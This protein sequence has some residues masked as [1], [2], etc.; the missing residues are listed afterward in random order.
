MI[1]KMKF[2]VGFLCFMAWMM[3]A[4]TGFAAP[5]YPKLT[6]RVVDKASLLTATEKKQL[7]NQLKAHEEKSSDQLVIVTLPSL[8][9]YD[10]AD[11]SLNLARHWKIGQKDKDNGVLLVIAPKENKVRI[12]VGYG[13][14]GTLTDALSKLIIVR[15][16]AP[17]YKRGKAYQA[18]QSG[19]NEII[20]VLSG[21]A[22]EVRAR[23]KP[24]PEPVPWFV[25]LFLL[26]SLGIV[27][28]VLIKW[29][30]PVSEEEK[31]RRKKRAQHR[32][33][34]RKDRD[35]DD[36]SSSSS[37][38]SSSGSRWFGGGG[39]FGGGGSSSNLGSSD[40]GGGG[41]DD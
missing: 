29:L 8:Q 34:S 7:T 31:R 39:D 32:K 33:K 6:G 1:V 27:I 40:D 25:W 13:L 28:F 17:L 24:L 26:G 37:R 41:D 12:E 10:I 36:S 22:D 30:M 4:V 20:A 14:E 21:N 5:I 15:V 11:F 35:D 16:V 23:F 9:G 18:I 2:S 38:S 3:V 19:T